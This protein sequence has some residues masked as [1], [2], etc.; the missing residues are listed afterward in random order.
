[1]KGHS[2]F[3][4]DMNEGFDITV[5][6]FNGLARYIAF[7]KRS[8]TAWGAGDFRAAFMQ[9]SRQMIVLAPIEREAW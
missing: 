8:G 7:K 5:G 3:N 6:F 2:Y 4:G 9:I 1:V